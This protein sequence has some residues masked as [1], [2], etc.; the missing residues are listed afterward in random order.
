MWAGARPASTLA[1]R[2]VAF[3][4]VENL[5]PNLENLWADRA[6]PAASH[7]AGKARPLLNRAPCACW[8]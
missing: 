1:T 2:P 7:G 8:S 4:N 3:E 5:T 6:N